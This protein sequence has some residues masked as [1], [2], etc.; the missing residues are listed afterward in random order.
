[1]FDAFCREIEAVIPAGTTVVLRGSAV[2]GNRWRD[3]SA[4]DA[5]GS[6]T[7]DLDITLV[8]A[9]AVKYFK[10]TGFF[11]PDVHS[12][13]LSD[14]D[15]DIAPQL[16]PLRRTL[17]AMVHR[18]VNIQA[19]REIV[20]QLRG[21]LLGQ[22]YLTLF[23]KPDSLSILA[24]PDRA[25]TLRLLTYNIRNGGVGRA[26]PIARVIASSEPDIV[27]LQEA[28]RPDVVA[29]IAGR[30]GMADWRSYRSQSL[31]FLSRAHVQF[32]A[33]HRPRFSRHAFIEV[34]PAGEQVR[35]FGVH[36]SALHAAWTERR[37][38]VEVQSLLRGIAQ[39]QHGFH[40]LAG[41]FN[42]LAPPEEM[43]VGRLPM[44]LRPFVWLSGGRI[45]AK[46]L[47]RSDR[48]VRRRR[49]PGRA[50]CVRSSSGA[51]RAVRTVIG[52]FSF[53]RDLANRPNAKT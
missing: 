3:G 12:R 9:D 1:L 29:E 37:R 45:R 22:P 2:T 36:L 34:A 49:A 32:A 52:V 18:P 41:D 40:V 5:D 15:P 21:D 44:R 23:A 13:P 33:S 48:A 42:T 28:T 8:G 38:L 16:V 10:V 30:T 53:F 27:L 31:A 51:G 50:G 7:S 25:L 39:H 20:I 46:P 35:L 19:S 26:G 47:R 24:P 43:D 17:T 6:G 11:V 14:D 4:F